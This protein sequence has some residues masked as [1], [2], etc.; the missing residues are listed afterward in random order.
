[1]EDKDY[2]KLEKAL[3]K[4]SFIM[5]I[6][7]I[8]APFF[9]FNQK[10]KA[11]RAQDLLKRDDL[12]KNVREVVELF[13][14]DTE[15][16]Y[17][18][19]QDSKG[20]QRELLAVSPMQLPRGFTMD[21]WYG[22]VGLYIKKTSPVAFD[23]NTRTYDMKDDTLYFTLYELAA[24]M[25]VSTGGKMIK[26]IKD[27]IRELKSTEYFSFANG[28]IYNKSKESY[29]KSKERGISL[30]IDYAFQAEKRTKS[31]EKYEKNSVRFNPLIVD[32]IKYEYIKYLNTHIYFSLPSGLTRALY[33]YI[34]G[35]KYDC[36]GRKFI[37]IKRSYDVLANKIPIEYRYYSDLR[38]KINKPLQNLIEAGILKD[39]L[40]GD[41][42]KISGKKEY[43]IYFI[44]KGGKDDLIEILKNKKQINDVEDD[45]LLSS[46]GEN[47]VEVEN[48]QLNHNKVESENKLK[49]EK[50]KFE[51]EIPEK[52]ESALLEMKVSENE[53]KRWIKE[54]DE[55]IIL[56]Y[57]L[58]VQHQLF[59]GR[60]IENPAGLLSIALSTSLPMIDKY[61]FID[62][63]I[64][65]KKN[66]MLMAQ[67]S[68]DERYEK[69]VHEEVEKFKGENQGMYIILSESWIEQIK[70][71]YGK[72]YDNGMLNDKDLKLYEEF[73]EMKSDSKLFNKV[74]TENIKI[75]KNIMTLDDF[76]FNQL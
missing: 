11:L 17:H 63:F 55:W 46:K 65:N 9:L 37:Y 28:M 30:I 22:L 47:S 2:E 67:E 4:N 14:K 72:L 6:N 40:Y 41:V 51:L 27:S 31:K 35:N 60:I 50:N 15:V 18:Q 59:Q 16:K 23:T 42:D 38:N 43:C 12:A 44:F 25:G 1:M 34:E 13:S 64:K 58:W 73:I 75:M 5:D 7:I 68:V 57:Y 52:M 29:I 24:F 39:Y 61:K 56:K 36:N 74:A 10:I 54:Y 48:A 62:E 66:E 49:E 53:A 69:Y 32:N 21:V 76:K 45:L 3:K 19:W 71:Q 8:E 70:Q 33:S 20:L 26:K